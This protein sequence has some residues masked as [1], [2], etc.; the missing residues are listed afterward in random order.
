VVASPD[1]ISRR[2]VQVARVAASLARRGSAL[3]C[4]SLDLSR[5]LPIPLHIESAAALFAELKQR[6]VSTEL[7][8]EYVKKWAWEGRKISGFDEYYFVGHQIREESLLFGKVDYIVT[9]K[10]LLMDIY[11][12][13]RYAGPTIARGIRA[14]VT[15]YYDACTEAGHKHLHVFLKR[16]K[17]YDP[18]G[19]FED[20]QTARS[21]DAEIKA[22]LQSLGYDFE[23]IETSE[24]A[25]KAYAGRLLGG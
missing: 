14:A 10:P 19:R 12:S 6:H 5:W 7:A 20:E 24:A 18:R 2:L 4:P 16:S 11:Y 3:A 8:R 9:D 21:M 13:E 22:L 25:I 15:S 1:R 17:P 23:E